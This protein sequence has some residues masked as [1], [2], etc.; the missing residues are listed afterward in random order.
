MAPGDTARL[1]HRLSSYS[2]VP[3]IEWPP[4]IDHPLVRQDFAPNDRPTFPAHRKVY[5]DGLPSVE[6][7]AA[8]PPVRL[9]RSTSWPG[10]TRRLRRHST[11]TGSPAS[12]TCRPGSC[13]SPCVGTAGGSCSALPGRP[14]DSSR[15]SSTWPHV[16]SPGC[17]MASTGMTRWVMRSARRPPGDRRRNDHRDHWDP[18]ADGMAV[19]GARAPAHLLGRRHD[20]REHA[21]ARRLGRLS[22]PA[23]DPLPRR[24]RRT[25]GW[26]RRDAGVSARH[27]HARAAARP[28]S[29]PGGEAATGAIDV[30]PVEFPLVYARPARRRRRAARRAVA[31]RAAARRRPSGD[32]RPRRG[33]PASRLGADAR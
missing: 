3:E 26:C 2:Y 23:P 17:A 9:R 25:A 12:S 21:R 33:H 8:W 19:R 27:R 4:P 29:S 11:W 22:A 24:G 20:A 5:P 16:A 15:S 13:A 6:L 10:A 28:R 31:D 30:A 7:P 32:R 1:Y 14:A 18:V